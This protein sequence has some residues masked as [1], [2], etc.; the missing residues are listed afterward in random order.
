MKHVTPEMIKAFK[1]R[2]HEKPGQEAYDEAVAA[3]LA[4]ALEVRQSA[5]RE[6]TNLFL[7]RAEHLA[8][9][10]KEYRPTMDQDILHSWAVDVVENLKAISPEDEL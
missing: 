7:A 4:A 1:V 8:K 3:G 10:R 2:F 6:A 9:L 5:H